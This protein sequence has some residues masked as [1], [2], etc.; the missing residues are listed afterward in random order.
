MEINPLANEL[1]SLIKNSNIELLS[2]TEEEDKFILH[3]S[4]NTYPIKIITDFSEYCFL[5]CSI[6]DLEDINS[7]FLN[8][9]EKNVNYITK[10]LKKLSDNLN[11]TVVQHAKMMDHFHIYQK[12]SKS[13]KAIIDFQIIERESKTLV[14]KFSRIHKDVSNFPKELLFNTNQI[15]QILKKEIISIN[16]NFKHQH[17][18]TPIDNNIYELSLKLKLNNPIIKEIKNKLG[19]DYIEMKISIEPKMYPFIPPKFE[20]VKPAIKL[21]LVQNLMN[22]KILKMEKTVNEMNN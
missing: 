4:I 2:F 21:P 7:Q 17:N 19:Y 16:E 14:D 22:L 8:S 9:D 20:F 12:I 10:Q 3:F 11:K 15:L 6:L 18:I 13:S 5:E 1:R